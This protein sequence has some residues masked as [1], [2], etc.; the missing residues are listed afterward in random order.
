MPEHPPPRVR[1]ATPADLPEI[2]RIY[3]WEVLHGVA[4]WD[5]EPWAL[6]RREQWFA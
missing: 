2:N 5:I 6:V 3:N 4:T 1:P